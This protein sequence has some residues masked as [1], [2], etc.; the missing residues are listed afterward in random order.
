MDAVKGSSGA[1]GLVT[2]FSDP[3]GGGVGATGLNEIRE[4]NT[5]GMTRVGMA[6]WKRVIQNAVAWKV[7]N[8]GYAIEM[9][10]LT[11]RGERGIC[12]VG[13]NCERRGNMRHQCTLTST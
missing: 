9:A 2:G 13:V 4:P 11:L 3:V 6:Q 8:G 10:Q 1:A 5:V 7:L 12:V